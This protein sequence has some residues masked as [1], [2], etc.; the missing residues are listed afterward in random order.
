MIIQGDC[1]KVLFQMDSES[2]HLVVTSPPYGDLRSYASTFDVERVAAG[3]LQV[4]VPGGVVVWVVG[5]TVAGGFKTGEPY[6]QVLAFMDAGLKLYDTM[7]YERTGMSFPTK[8]RYTQ[9]FDHMFVFSKGK[10]RVVRLIRDIPKLWEGSWGKTMRRNKDG[11]LTQA[12]AKNEG[13]AKSGRAKVENEDVIGTQRKGVASYGYKARSAIWKIANG[14]GFGHSDE[15]GVK[16]PATF[17]EALAEGHILTWT[18]EGETVLD[19][20][21]GSG[22]T[23]KMASLNHRKAIGIEIE[24]KYCEIARARLDAASRD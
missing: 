10:P 6:R 13:L 8:A 23:L 4:M 18:N 20:F 3:L 21:C 12:H 15:F 14:K 19:P 5:D 17:P 16:H 7:I 1:S 9:N 11:T 22:T 2:V 24:E